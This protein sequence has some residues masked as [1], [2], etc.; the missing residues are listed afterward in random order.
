M[1]VTMLEP[2]ASGLPS[3]ESLALAHRVEFYPLITRS[4]HTTSE[5][6]RPPH[7]SSPS[8]PR[9]SDATSDEVFMLRPTPRKGGGA[10]SGGDAS[11]LGVGASQTPT[12]ATA[13]SS[14]S[15][16]PAGGAPAG[17]AAGDYRTSPVLVL[18]YPPECPTR[19]DASPL[20]KALLR[21]LV[22]DFAAASTDLKADIKAITN[23]IAIAKGAAADAATAAEKTRARLSAAEAHT[24]GLLEAKRSQAAR[25]HELV[26]GEKVGSPSPAPP[27]N[28]GGVGGSG[29]ATA[30][31][32]V[33]SPAR[34]LG[35]GVALRTGGAATAAAGH[36]SPPPL[37]VR[38]VG[39]DNAV[40]V[41]RFSAM[42]A[43][44]DGNVH[45]S[46]VEWK[47]RVWESTMAQTR[48]D[49]LTGARDALMEQLVGVTA[50][51]AARRSALLGRVWRAL[52]AVWSAQV[53][54]RDAA[55]ACLHVA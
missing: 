13:G 16:T 48:L 40:A 11:V 2:D 43:T 39:A 37:G 12:T 25:L 27:Q 35:P 8:T 52:A 3:N 15:V 22:A 34:P 1:K 44:L 46:S 24:L 5:L 26:T 45:D 50:E 18:W 10:A 20:A 51:T 9:V 32:T 31:S 41:K 28:V 14:L 42:I 36:L 6:P 23:K 47:K 53:G 49:E 19:L 30:V 33:I 29:G 7:V 17:G 21:A 54:R 4:V 38:V 55:I